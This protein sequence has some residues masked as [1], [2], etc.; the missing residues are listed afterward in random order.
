MARL[1]DTNNLQALKPLL[2]RGRHPTLNGTLIPDRVT[3]NSTKVR[4][5]LVDCRQIF[6]SNTRYMKY[7]VKKYRSGFRGK[8]TVV[9]RLTTGIEGIR[10]VWP[11]F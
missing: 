11:G 6:V 10:F 2:A 4:N 5:V 1:T 8:S 3:P 9:H 7:N